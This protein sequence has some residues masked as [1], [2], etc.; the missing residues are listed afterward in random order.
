MKTLAIILLVALGT[1]TFSCTI[2]KVK[3]VTSGSEGGGVYYSLGKP[4][5][6][7]TPNSSGNG[8]YD[9]ELVYIP[10]HNQTYA[11]TSTAIMTKSVMEVIVDESGII[12]KIDWT[13]EGDKEVSEALTGASEIVK[14]ELEKNKK[15]SEEDEENAKKKKQNAQSAVVALKDSIAAKKLSI[16]IIDKELDYLKKTYPKPSA[17]IGK[18]MREKDLERIKLQLEIEDLEAKL[19][20]AEDKLLEVESAFNDPRSDDSASAYGPVF[21]EIVDNYDPFKSKAE[22][23]GGGVSLK[24]MKV[25]GGNEQMQFETVKEFTKPTAPC[26]APKFTAEGN[27]TISFAT[28]DPIINLKFT[29][30]ISDI[31]TEQVLIAAVGRTVTIPEKPINILLT[32]KQE[33]AITFVKKLIK[34]KYIITIPFTYKCDGRET[35]DEASL[36]ANFEVK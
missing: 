34:G 1:F 25:F 20:S 10:D 21:F 36:T 27:F 26:K 19:E 11:V 29:S 7:V 28:A 22:N 4:V 3:K 16:V 31:S 17:A 32:D 18:L 33:L 24:A 13:G 8:T 9:V 23:A 12:K 14:G 5:I 15:E 6:K 35:D 2:V 30:K